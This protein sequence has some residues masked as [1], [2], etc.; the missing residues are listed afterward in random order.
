MSNLNL[1]ISQF[2]Y[3]DAFGELRLSHGWSLQAPSEPDNNGSIGIYAV[4]PSGHF[5]DTTA[6]T[7]DGRVGTL[8]DVISLP[9]FQKI[10]LNFIK[11][12]TF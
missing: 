5:T 1:E 3:D 10:I 9:E 8:P 6:F 12:F 2:Y 11:S 7:W 4:N